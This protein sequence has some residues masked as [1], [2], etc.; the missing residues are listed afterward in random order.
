MSITNRNGKIHNTDKNSSRELLEKE[1]LGSDT[2]K[3]L[4]SFGQY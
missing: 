4:E 1:G 2:G 3:V